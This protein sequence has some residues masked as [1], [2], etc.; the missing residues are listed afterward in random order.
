MRAETARWLANRAARLSW[1][2]GRAGIAEEA[3]TGRRSPRYLMALGLGL[4]RDLAIGEL[5]R[6]KA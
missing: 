4:L 1:L 6:M 3:S 5:E 2:Q